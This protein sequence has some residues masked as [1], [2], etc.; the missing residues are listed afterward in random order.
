MM[1]YI[2]SYFEQFKTDYTFINNIYLV[3]FTFQ[4]Q[5]FMVPIIWKMVKWV[6][7]VN[8]VKMVKWVDNGK[9]VNRDKTSNNIFGGDLL[10]MI[11][12]DYTFLYQFDLFQISDLYPFD[13]KCHQTNTGVCGVSMQLGLWMVEQIQRNC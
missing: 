7:I 11:N 5:K 3:I 10:M 13:H 1:I 12:I 2:A 6:K 4:S 9:G 8:W